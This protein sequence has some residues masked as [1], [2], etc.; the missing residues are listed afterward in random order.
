MPTFDANARCLK[1]LCEQ[2]VAISLQTSGK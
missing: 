1:V 2:H